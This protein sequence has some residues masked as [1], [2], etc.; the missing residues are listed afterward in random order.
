MVTMVSD[1][2]KWAD[3]T[4]PHNNTSSRPAAVPHLLLLHFPAHFLRVSGH[5]GRLNQGRALNNQNPCLE[6]VPS[7]H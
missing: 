6:Q 1:P 3:A 5:K 4:R 7:F 2:V